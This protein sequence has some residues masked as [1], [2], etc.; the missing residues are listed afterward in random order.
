ML[1][2]SANLDIFL[3]IRGIDRVDLHYL[4]VRNGMLSENR[5]WD[6]LQPRLPFSDSF[7]TDSLWADSLAIDSMQLTEWEPYNKSI[8]LASRKIR[9]ARNNV[10]PKGEVNGNRTKAWVAA[11]AVLILLVVVIY[12]KIYPYQFA[13]QLSAMFN[14]N[15]FKELTETQTDIYRLSRWLSVFTSVNVLGLALFVAF[16]HYN[17]KTDYSSFTL[18]LIILGS[19]VI[20]HLAQ[21]TLRSIYANTFEQEEFISFYSL[22]QRSHGFY[23]ALYAL[24]V[25]LICYYQN[26]LIFRDIFDILLLIVILLYLAANLSR[27]VYAN[28]NKHKGSTLYLFLYLCAFEI[29]PLLVV[30]KYI[31]NLLF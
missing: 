20:I 24:P 17:I 2:D 11:W 10:L 8:F 19:L 12:K 16:S 15:K 7:T 21:R 9:N 1:N 14:Q 23:F 18:F 4:M 13:L 26:S 30:F 3:K 29:L 22:V 31:N 27:G 6:S 25:L 5:Y 28:Y